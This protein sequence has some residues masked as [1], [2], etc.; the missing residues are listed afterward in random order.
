M[1]LRQKKLGKIDSDKY[2]ISYA[3][4]FRELWLLKNLLQQRFVVYIGVLI[5]KTLLRIYIRT[6]V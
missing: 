6:Y 3:T 2:T 1:F 4:K 5:L